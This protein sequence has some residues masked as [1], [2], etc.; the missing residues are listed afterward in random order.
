MGYHV[1][2]VGAGSATDPGPGERRGTKVG[3][4]GSQDVMMGLWFAAYAAA[5]QGE[6][7]RVCGWVREVRG[8][9][10]G[11]PD[12]LRPNSPTAVRAWI[13]FNADECA[14][15]T[16]ASSTIERGL[17]LKPVTDPDLAVLV[18]WWAQ[19]NDWTDGRVLDPDLVA[20]LADV[21]D[22]LLSQ[23]VTSCWYGKMADVAAVFRYAAGRRLAVGYG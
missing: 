5:G 21:C 22:R 1:V 9:P 23:L 15:L 12:W 2:A 11:H 19:Y 6:A 20:N 4:Y 16:V 3:P 13:G 14:W 7:K 8:A 18:A 17:K 10:E